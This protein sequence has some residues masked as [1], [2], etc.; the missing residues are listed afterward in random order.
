MQPENENGWSFL[1]KKINVIFSGIL[2]SLQQHDGEHALQY[3][4][5]LQ[6]LDRLAFFRA[7][8][9]YEAGQWE[10]AEEKLLLH[11]ALF[12][13]DEDACFFL[14]NVFYREGRWLDALQMYQKCL[15]WR[16]GFFEAL[17]NSALTLKNLV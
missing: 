5:H 9:Y 7:M 3:F 16:Q 8:A 6:N 1:K 11:L 4:S 13:K 17:G 2:K 10:K 15:E 14:G 12:D